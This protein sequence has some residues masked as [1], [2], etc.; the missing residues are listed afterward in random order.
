MDIV[1]QAEDS[2]KG[3]KVERDLKDI[4]KTL[5]AF[6][7]SV[8]PGDTATLSIGERDD[9][10]VQES[11]NADNIQKKVKEIAEKFIQRFTIE[12]RNMSRMVSNELMQAILVRHQS[13]S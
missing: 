12:R 10:T 11:T 1:W 3:K 9:G 5:V 4:L 8:I 13:T 7:N 2:L 6:A